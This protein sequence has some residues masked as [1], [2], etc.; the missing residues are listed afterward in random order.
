MKIK[1]THLDFGK[2][3]DTSTKT[4]TIDVKNEGKNELLIHFEEI[5][6]HLIFQ[7]RPEKLHP[8]RS[9]RIVVT[10]NAQKRDNYGLLHDEILICVVSESDTIGQNIQ[11]SAS[12]E[13]DF[14]NISS[15][16]A[17]YLIQKNRDNENFVI[18]DVRTPEEFSEGQIENAINIDYYSEKFEEEIQKL[19]KNKRY[20]CYC[21]KGGRSGKSLK[22]M[23][24]FGFKFAL[25]NLEEGIIGWEKSGF[26]IIKK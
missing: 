12:I 3:K 9:G 16:N 19:D 10:Y 11:I 13:G 24:K 17:N 1:S 26:P 18:L 8:N 21:K 2:I 6:E 4:K 20:F 15:K 14:S 25:Y 7:I 22:I 5:P 23:N